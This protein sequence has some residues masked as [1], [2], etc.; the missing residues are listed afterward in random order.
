MTDLTVGG[1]TAPIGLDDRTPGLGWMMHI[2]QQ[3]N[4][5]QTAYR[6]LVGTS[7]T[8]VEQGVGNVW[9]SGRV[10]SE[11][12]FG[13]PFGGDSLESYADYYWKVQVW[14]NQGDS[15]SS[16]VGHWR[17]GI[18]DKRE[19]K[20]Q[21]IGLDT[22]SEQDAPHRTQT[23][24]A[25][26]YLRKE[27]ALTKPV[28]KATVVV[29]GLGLYELQINGQK[30][31]DDVLS[32]TL[33]DYARQVPYNTYDVRHLLDTGTNAIGV[34]LGNGRFFHLRDFQGGPNPVTGIAHVNYGYPRLLLQL[35]IQYADGTETLVVTDPSWK[36]T[37]K[38]PIRA[39]N[40]Y[41][42]EEFDARMELD[43]WSERGY[44]DGHWA[45]ADVMEA[46]EGTL[47]A[48]A[49][50]NIRIKE[51]V[52][53][54]A[55]RETGRGTYLLD[56]GQ[57]M[58]GWLRIQVRGNAGDTVTM[59]FAERLSDST[60][61]YLDNLRDA[62]VTDTY[63]LKGGGVETWQPRFTYHGFRYVELAGLSYEPVITDFE[64]QVVYDDVAT[65]G[66]FETS[67]TTINQV[68]NNAYWSIRGN[69]RGIP[70]DCP[71]RDE[72]VAWL[73]DRLMSSYGESFVFDN[74]RIYR[75]WMG[76]TQAA[77]DSN[78][79]LPDIVPEYWLKRTDNIT[80]PSAFIIIPHM[81][82]KQFGDE[83]TFRT[84][85]PDMKKW[86]AYMWEKYREGDL[87][88]RDTYGDWCVPPEEGTEEIWTS[89]PAKTT[90]GGLL[91]SAYHYYC[92][93]LMEEF[94]ALQGL[95]GDVAYF[96]GLRERVARAFNRK[97]FNEQGGYYGNN[98]TT[99]NLL[100][101]TFGLVPEGRQAAV[102]Q[103]IVGRLAAHGYHVNSGIMGMMWFM[104][105][106]T[107]HGRADLAYA[108]ASKR[109]YPSWG[110][111]VENGA[112]TIWELWNGN[113]AHPLMNSWN[114]QMLLGDLL[115]WYFEYLAGIQ[116]D[117]NQVAFKRV[118][119]KPV[120]PE[121]LHEVKASYRSK[122][123]VIKSHWKR[124]AEK[125]R[126]SIEVPPNSSALVGIP[127]GDAGS[128]NEGGR[129]LSEVADVLVKG[130]ED[131]RVLLE[132][133]SGSY[134]FQA[135]LH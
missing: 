79:S 66:S 86:L 18:L 107:D 52:V 50:E 17:M 37:D 73:G 5:R 7:E 38:G 21:W 78:G 103:Q 2:E 104:R 133:G 84:Y 100:P 33:T 9:D 64:G 89:D 1:R 121:G 128:I 77:Q 71:Q 12:S 126:W 30:V 96:A 54:E 112:T 43:G 113:T 49:N 80:Y 53:P 63:V 97:F 56:M 19:W 91:A 58:V 42:G 60:T 99:A 22:V 102:F 57:N 47:M 115:I 40:E 109:T 8:L 125:L 117:T 127:A 29:S 81:L 39:N 35:M 135:D 101:L 31:G 65:I 122:F 46:P 67:D 94:A 10:L 41:D 27:V 92:L 24:L 61:L 4:I 98:T 20:A 118:V 28:A 36:V 85:Y 59:R 32:P 74:S 111:M 134:Q 114:H 11:A 90:D 120:F 106:L 15:A 26:R 110:Y 68:F 69:Y 88:L 132:I 124:D 83:E 34:I 16:E 123:G 108:I 82:R 45:V 55:I 130:V 23:R 48:Q 14:T 3:R 51:T 6:I 129:P 105:G 72:R 62:R 70:T 95:D 44:D 25:A 75:K 119:M 116:S 87:I 13:V 131:G 93:T 76:D